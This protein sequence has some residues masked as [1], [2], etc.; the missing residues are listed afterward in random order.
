MGELEG[1]E[2]ADIAIAMGSDPA[3]D[4]VVTVAGELD[5]SNVGELEAALSSILPEP[6]RK[7]IFD[8]SGLQF[9]DSAG[10]GALLRSASQ[11]QSVQ[12]RDPSPAVRR[13]V[14][15]TGLDHVL[16]IEPIEP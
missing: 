7:L 10:I 6:S 13:V 14:E 4:P 1:E 15:L 9:M 5:I 12:L 11:V 16:S 8:L 2:T 3:G